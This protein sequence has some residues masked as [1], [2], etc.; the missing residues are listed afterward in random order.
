MQVVTCQ[1]ALEY[2]V[3]QSIIFSLPRGSSNRY[4]K[5]SVV[6]GLHSPS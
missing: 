4:L 6:S 3:L 1:E 5:Q 2:V